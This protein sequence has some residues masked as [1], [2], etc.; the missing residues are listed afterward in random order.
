MQ[1]VIACEFK[2]EGSL[3]QN[4]ITL[5]FRNWGIENDTD[6]QETCNDLVSHGSYNFDRLMSFFDREHDRKLYLLWLSS[7]LNNFI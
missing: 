3:V 6:N 7:K 1:N 5:F 2:V 4:D